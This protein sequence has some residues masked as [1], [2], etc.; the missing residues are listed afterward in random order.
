MILLKYVPATMQGLVIALGIIA[1]LQACATTIMRLVPLAARAYVEKRWPWMAWAAHAVRTGVT[2]LVAFLTACLN[3]L[4]NF[5]YPSAPVLPT[6]GA[7]PYRTSALDVSKP[8]R[9]PVPPGAAGLIMGVLLG[10]MAFGL[11]AVTHGCGAGT[12]TTVGLNGSAT[13]GVGG[14]TWTGAVTIAISTAQA[15]LPVAEAALDSN[16]TIPAGTRASI[17]QAFRV[18]GDSLSIAARD[19]RA[20]GDASSIPSQ[21]A[22]HND[23]ELAIT[24]AIQG[25][26]LA[27][28][29][30][31]KV[32]PMFSAALGG[33]GTVADM[34]WPNCAAS[35]PPAERISAQ[36]RISLA[37]SGR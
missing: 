16:A 34:L 20:I 26:H 4:K 33:L 24:N 2:D 32:D 31:A 11:T 6:L 28:D 17:D 37:L 9:Q 29:A 36:R 22:V 21:C 7:M 27:S 25:V 30:G 12:T 10:A 14:I 13:P 8:P 19:V 3:V 1:T 23:V 35:G 15:A 18:A 5:P